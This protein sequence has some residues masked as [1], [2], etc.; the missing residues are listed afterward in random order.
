MKIMT[1]LERSDF[2][3]RDMFVKLPLFKKSVNLC[4]TFG[5]SGSY[6]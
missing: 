6:I 5:C 2:E 4:I 1:V 3:S